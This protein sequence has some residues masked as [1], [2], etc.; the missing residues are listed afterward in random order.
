MYLVQ[1]EGGR[2]PVENKAYYAAMPAFKYGFAIG[3]LVVLVAAA[4]ALFFLHRAAL[5]LFSLALAGNLGL[6]VWHVSTGGL[7]DVWHHG[8][9]ECCSRGHILGTVIYFAHRVTRPPGGSRAGRATG[10]GLVDGLVLTPGETRF[11][12]GTIRRRPTSLA[13]AARS[14]GPRRSSAQSADRPWAYPGR[15]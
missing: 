9:L 1:R 14:A 4:V 7:N 13:V 6:A 15:C 10:A 3:L 8:G 11:G 12:A 5:W 2:M